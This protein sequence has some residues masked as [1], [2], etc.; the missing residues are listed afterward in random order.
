MRILDLFC[1]AGGASMGYHR[2][3]PDAQ[4]VGVDIADQ[5]RYPFEF[6]RADAM[7]FPTDGFDFVHAS[8][9]CQHYTTMSNRWRGKGGK[10]DGHDDLIAATRN[11]LTG[12]VYV[13]ENVPGARAEMSGW[14]ITLT[15]GMFGLGV[16]RP[17]L[18]EL[19]HPILSLPPSES[20]DG[21]LGV[22]GSL[23][24]RRLWTRADGSE[25]R[26]PSTLAEAQAAMGVDWMGWDELRESIP[27]A[28]TE[29]IGGELADLL[30]RAAA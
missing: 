5:P 30:E 26:A 18:F 27:P 9:P 28:Y 24:G 3:W 17:R 19:S 15:G 7:T 12:H 22:Y 1:G 8:P 2:A 13:I 25:L 14:T 6:V 29:F 21:L 20:P 11:R 16:H 4:I 10:A 23:D